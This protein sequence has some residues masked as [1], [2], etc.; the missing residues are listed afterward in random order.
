MKDNTHF[1]LNF[2]KVIRIL[3][4]S[5]IVTMDVIFVYFNIPDE[6]GIQACKCFFLRS[7]DFQK[8]RTQ[9]ITRIKKNSYPGTTISISTAAIFFKSAIGTKIPPARR[10]YLWM[11]W[12]EICKVD[13]T[14][15]TTDT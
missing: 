14:Y 3:N 9:Y 5:L 15:T 12:N 6:E 2:A 1:L 11:P 4:D 10:T 8:H 13:I 7:R